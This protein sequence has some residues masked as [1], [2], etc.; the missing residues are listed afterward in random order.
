VVSDDKWAE[1]LGRSLLS[2]RN[3]SRSAVSIIEIE[4]VAGL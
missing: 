4:H 3:M 1:A 2:G